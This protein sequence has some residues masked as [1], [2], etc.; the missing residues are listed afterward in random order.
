MWERPSAC[1][2]VALRADPTRVRQDAWHFPYILVMEQ[3]IQARGW[4][5]ED[6][7]TGKRGPKKIGS[8]WPDAMKG[9]EKRYE[10]VYEEREYEVLSLLSA[11]EREYE[12]M[13]ILPEDD[14]DAF[15]NVN[16][17]FWE[18]REVDPEMLLAPSSD[19]I[20]TTSNLDGPST[21]FEAR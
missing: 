20:S 2:I 1:C 18:K 19:S 5:G 7:D 21:E 3:C 14:D 11:A 8:R 4:N 6:L 9:A 13:R 10:Y 16:V 15:M 12:A 17:G